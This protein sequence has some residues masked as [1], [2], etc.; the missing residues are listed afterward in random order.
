MLR[1]ILFLAILS[2]QSAPVPS[3]LRTADRATGS[4]PILSVVIP[5]YPQF[6]W[7]A[8]IQYSVSLRM[9]V[10]GDGRVGDARVL[11]GH[12]VLNKACEA[13]ARQ[14]RFQPDPEHPSRT[15]DVM[16]VFTLVSETAPDSEVTSDL[17]LTGVI[18]IRARAG[19]VAEMP[20]H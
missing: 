12:P 13:A 9:I 7:Q 18:H 5:G 4:L 1:A 20:S 2:G 17:D 3:D 19:H 16:F 10:S 14:W 15:F 6:A 8:G 11:R